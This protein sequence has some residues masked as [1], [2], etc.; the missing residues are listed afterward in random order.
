MEKQKLTKS[1]I[2]RL[3][4][5]DVG[6]RY[7]CWDSDLKGYGVRVSATEKTFVVF[8]RI[9]GKLTRVTL[10]KHGV[11]T[12]D[13]AR[14]KAIKVL[15]ELC[16]GIDVNAEKARARDRGMTV[17]D[18]LDKYFLMVSQKGHVKL[19]CRNN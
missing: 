7:E 5:A 8:K 3:P 19:T 11:L 12:A 4:F 6:K 14:K 15:A 9:G 10:G 1:A 16:D 13:E 18:I 2:D 17:A